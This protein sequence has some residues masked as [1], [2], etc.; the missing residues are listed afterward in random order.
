MVSKG[1]FAT[2]LIT[3]CFLI[4]D[5]IEKS[6]GVRKGWSSRDVGINERFTYTYDTSNELDKNSEDAKHPRLITKSGTLE[7]PNTTQYR[8]QQKQAADAARRKYLADFGTQ[9]SSNNR[10]YTENEINQIN[11][12]RRNPSGEIEVNGEM[13]SLMRELVSQNKVLKAEIDTIKK[14]SNNR[15]LRSPKIK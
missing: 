5:E 7:A 13:L 12:N 14:S 8:I 3:K 11:N 10:I 1:K 15:V 6:Q 2:D 4:Q 9:K